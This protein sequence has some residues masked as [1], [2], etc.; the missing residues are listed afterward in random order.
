MGLPS[1]GTLERLAL[2]AEELSEAI[3]VVN[4]IIRHGYN[5]YHPANSQITNKELLEKE[6]GHVYYAINLSAINNEICMGEIAEH[7]REKSKSVRQ[8]L[9]FQTPMED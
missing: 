6:L 8:W 3:Q 1:R 7:C 5:N 9:Y 2:L 4:K